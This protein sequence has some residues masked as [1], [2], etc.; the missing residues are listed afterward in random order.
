MGISDQKHLDFLKE[1][2]IFQTLS[3]DEIK[4]IAAHLF[5]KEIKEGDYVF[6]RFENEQ[7]L[8]IVRY[9]KLVLETALDAENILKK[10]DVFGEIAVINNHYRTGTIKAEEPALLFCLEGKVLFEVVPPVTAMKIIIEMAKLISSYLSTAQN[11]STARL[12]EGG[13]NESVEFKSTL[14]YNI[15][16]GKFDKE[17]E[18][19]ALK[20]IAA[21]LNSSGGTLLIGVNDQKQLLGLKNDNFRDDDHMLLHLTKLIQERISIKQTQFVRAQV[22]NKDNLKILRIDVKAS[23]SPAYLDHNGEEELYVRTGPATTPMKV[24]EVYTYLKSRFYNK[25]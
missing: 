15:H 2:N 21:F 9:G 5:I 4:A 11:T 23:T 6:S 24:S 20:T 17:I 7:V 14:R 19:A 25:V 12:I 13:E 3:E 16:T 10:G 1:V 18:H 8:Y 22:E